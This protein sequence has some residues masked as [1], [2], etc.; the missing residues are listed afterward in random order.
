MTARR[1]PVVKARWGVLPAPV[2][3]AV[4]HRTG[5]VSRVDDIA[6]GHNSDL[7]TVLHS[8]V[9]RP[10]FLK[11]VKGV[12]RRMQ[13]LRNE[14]A[15]SAIASGVAPYVYFHLDVGD[16]FVVGFE[17][18]PGRPV[19][20]APGSPDLGVVTEILCT[21]GGMPAGPTIGPLRLRWEDASWWDRLAAEAPKHVSGVDH[22][23][24][25]AWASRASE[26][27]NG[28]R[29]VHTDL[30]GDQFLV[31]DNAVH[32][33]DWGF[34][35]SGAPWVDTAFLVIR[36]IHHGHAPEAADAW[37]RGVPA[38][39]DA[40]RDSVTAF[41]A[42]IAGMWTYWHA[43][44]GRSNAGRAVAARRYVGWLLERRTLE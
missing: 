35:G 16:W 44:E 21:I 11:G 26:F 14:V 23:Q 10:V 13:Y 37:A 4:Q 9:G 28:G 22:E 43:C 20:L 17:Y 27:V 15:A 6:A 39:A 41:A 34:P 30:H 25:S 33:I 18:A 8:S 3:A 1:V 36:L 42:Y 5:P 7:T 19:S 32:V 29:L 31:G 40:D 24:L 2:R 12:S 38:Y